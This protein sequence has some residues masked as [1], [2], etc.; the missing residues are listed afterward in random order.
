MIA[1]GNLISK[2]QGEGEAIMYQ[3]FIPDQT[4]MNQM[5]QIQ[6]AKEEKRRKKEEE[7][8][9]RKEEWSSNLMKNYK[10]NPLDSETIKALQEDAVN[11][12]RN[13]KPGDDPLA[14]DEKIMAV[15]VFKNNSQETFVKTNNLIKEINPKLETY[16]VTGYDEL[17]SGLVK[18]PAKTLEEGASELA[19]RE[20]LLDNVYV[21]QK[22]INNLDVDI[23]ANAKTITASSEPKLIQSKDKFGRLVTVK[24]FEYDPD[25]VRRASDRFYESHSKDM[26][27][28]NLDK[29]A[30]YQMHLEKL[31]TQGGIS[32]T[33]Q[34]AP[35][36]AKVGGWSAGGGAYTIGKTSFGT[37]YDSTQ[38]GT[39]AQAKGYDSW[40]KKSV[41]K[42][43]SDVNS[44]AEYDDYTDETKAK[45][46]KEEIERRKKAL[47][48][49]EQFEKNTTK[50]TNI[51]GNFVP[52]TVEGGAE[53]SP[54]QFNIVESDG[55]Q[56]QIKG[57]SNLYDATHKAFVVNTEQG[58]VLAPL[59]AN[60]SVAADW[61]STKD[62]PGS[63]ELWEKGINERLG[64][65][66]TTN[67]EFDA[68][69][70]AR[71]SNVMA[72]NPNFTREEVIKA[73]RAAKKIK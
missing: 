1:D 35:K 43:E 2:G 33:K 61:S 48:A 51:S 11:A 10:Y 67:Q 53:N 15:D 7:D 59:N 26:A 50:I 39:F 36:S 46:K 73:L 63:I 64:I 8:A 68:D 18:S 38:K 3:P 16:H 49:K 41:E 58:T 30:L 57:T 66:P 28:F 37:P 29:D 27:E 14:I 17:K 72:K 44:S 56:T 47:P 25:E 21:G 6:A 23:T 42:I 55:R 40:Y 32:I 19:K 70:E 65:T 9:K 52:F 12:I 34:A 5:L 24:E 13:Y 31:K 69:T 62:T 45:K 60:E 20:L 54:H 71:I 22:K 4:S